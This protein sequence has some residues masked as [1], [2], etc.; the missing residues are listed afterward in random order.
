L[1]HLSH[2]DG[3]FVTPLCALKFSIQILFEISQN[4]RSKLKLSK[5]TLKI[6]LKLSSISIGLLDQLVENVS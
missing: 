1:T 4:G 3:E 2:C 6:S 5:L